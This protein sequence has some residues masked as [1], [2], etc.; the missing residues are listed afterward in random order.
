M[1]HDDTG[2]ITDVAPY[3]AL[4]EHYDIMPG[5]QVYGWRKGAGAEGAP[6]RLDTVWSAKGRWC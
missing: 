5:D 2:A 3:P 4:Y 6:E 1:Q